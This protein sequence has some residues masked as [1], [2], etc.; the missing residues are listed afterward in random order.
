MKKLIYSALAF[1]ALG[2][3]S[4]DDESYDDWAQPIT[5]AQEASQ[6]F[7]F[8]ATAVDAINIADVEAD[9]V[10]VFNPS[11]SLS[12]NNAT[13]NNF[14]VLF[15]DGSLISADAN[16]NVLV[17]DLVSVVEAFYGK[18]PELR[19]LPAS[20]VA[21]VNR[22]GQFMKSDT[23][24]L[25]IKA[26]LVTPDIANAYYI[27]GGPL[28]WAA[29]ASSK[30]LKFNHSETNVYDDPVFTITFD[31]AAEGDTWFAIGDDKACDAIANSNDWSQL[32]GVVGGNSE[33]TS[34]SLDR[35]SVLGADNS[36]KVAAGAKK[37]KVSINMI[38]YTFTVEALNFEEYIYL[39]G[40][41]QG[42]SPET[43]PALKHQG[44][45]VYTGFAYMDGEFKFTR[46][47]NW[48]SEYN[49]GNFT[50]ASE[51]FSLEKGDGG[52]I[53]NSAA[54]LYYF[55][56]DVA[57]GN[58][59]ATKITNMNLVGDFNGWKADDD[60]QQMTWNAT[61]LCYEITGAT[62]TDAGWKFTA[63]NDWAINLGG[64]LTDL[65]GNGGNLSAV[66]TTIKL[67][68]CRTT[69]DEIYATVE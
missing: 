17:D 41:A 51:G 30:E 69:K 56:V 58:L 32:F 60:A 19:T 18:A 57:N 65:V 14:N 13:V 24:K 31:A 8:S 11:V 3:A 61:D 27:V 67:Y 38:D 36:F 53:I 39:P 68:P 29:S 10:K 47:R 35:R 55:E 22:D 50:T 64:S 7:S 26:T 1:A 49:A 4:C 46:A 25:E 33:S 23:V 63:N 44:N 40:N 37:I 48:S 62:V 28:D 6:S 21:L 43:A 15:S 5:N 9:V 12:D 45:G 66:G 52:N 34:G 59:K 2:F 20:V 54:G 16:G 42:W